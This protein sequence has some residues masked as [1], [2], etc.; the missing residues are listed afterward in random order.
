MAVLMALDAKGHDASQPGF[1]FNVFK[2][3]MMRTL[4]RAT[5]VVSR[6]RR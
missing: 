6:D 2:F 1:V 4:Q 5:F 3:A